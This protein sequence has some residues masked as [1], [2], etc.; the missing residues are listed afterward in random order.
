MPGAASLA[1]GV[2]LA[3]LLHLSIGKLACGDDEDF[4]G[5]LSAVL[6]QLAGLRSLEL[7]RIGFGELGDVLNTAPDLT[8]S[9]LTIGLYWP[10]EPEF[11]DDEHYE[12]DG[13]GRDEYYEAARS[14]VT[15]WPRSLEL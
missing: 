1:T 10:L 13:L 11:D 4:G 9:R 8:L 7:R 12:V 14:L 15:T 2:N 3:H 6:S 5:G